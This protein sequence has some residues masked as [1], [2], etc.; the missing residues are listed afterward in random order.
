MKSSPQNDTSGG[1]AIKTKTVPIPKARVM[2]HN[3]SI[4]G[5]KRAVPLS[6][7]SGSFG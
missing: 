1:P 2:E 5:R 3:V 7:L 4:V 6:N